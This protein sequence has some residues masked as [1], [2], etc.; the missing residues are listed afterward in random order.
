MTDGR[1]HAHMLTD[2]AHMRRGSAERAHVLQNHCPKVTYAA[3]L[4][5]LL[6]CEL[7]GTLAD[8]LDSFMIRRCFHPLP[9]DA[10]GRQL[11]YDEEHPLASWGS[12][13]VEEGRGFL[14]L[15]SWCQS[16]GSTWSGG[17][18][19]LQLFGKR[20]VSCGSC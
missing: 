11:L 9:A 14:G 10:H 2:P 8:A 5:G 6:P 1:Y 3:Y 20:I 13:L 18:G 17:R 15:A 4:S 19:E 16:V 12:F 7:T